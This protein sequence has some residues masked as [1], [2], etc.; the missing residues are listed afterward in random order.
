VGRT[1]HFNNGQASTCLQLL[2]PLLFGASSL[3]DPFS[4]RAATAACR[5]VWAGPRQ[6]CR[7]P[8]RQSDESVQDSDD[9]DG[10]NEEEESGRLERVRQV[11]VLADVTG[12]RLRYISSKWV[13]QRSSRSK[14][15]KE[16]RTKI[17]TEYM[18]T[19]KLCSVA[20]PGF[21]AR[22]GKAGN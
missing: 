5:R 11:A 12:R 17:S 6:H 10:R 9:R 4:S 8:D 15:L 19:A 20:S 14:L 1:Q 7:A 3:K 13:L 18:E 22:R 2:S 16:T 21:V